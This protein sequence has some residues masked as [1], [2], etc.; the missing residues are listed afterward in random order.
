MQD[1]KVKAS[2]KSVMGFPPKDLYYYYYYYYWLIPKPILFKLALFWNPVQKYSPVGPVLFGVVLL[3]L[4]LQ[5][6]L[7]CVL[8]VSAFNMCL[9]LA[10]TLITARPSQQ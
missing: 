1:Y 2:K 4:L 3:L 9:I 8:A 6:V 5:C 7:Q 10:A